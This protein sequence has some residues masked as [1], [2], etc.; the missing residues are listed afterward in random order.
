MFIV[1]KPWRLIAAG[2]VVCAFSALAAVFVCPQCGYENP[3]DAVTC[4]HC[5]ATL[6]PH[7]ATTETVKQTAPIPATGDNRWYMPADIVEKEIKLARDYVKTGDVAVARLF[8]KNAMALDLITDPSIE[9]KRAETIL[10]AIEDCNTRLCQ[11]TGKCPVCKGTGDRTVQSVD[12]QGNPILKNVIGKGCVMCNGRGYVNKFANQDELKPVLGTG[13][14]RYKMIQEGRKYVT[15]G[16]AWVPMALEEKL[17]VKQTAMLKVATATPCDN[18]LGF[19]TVACPTCNGVGK[20]KCPTCKGTG[21]APKDKKSDSN[22]DKKEKKEIGDSIQGSLAKCLVCN[23]TGVISCDK[24]QGGQTIMCPRCNGTGERPAC[25]ACDGK[26]W[27]PCKKCFGSGKLKDN[28]ICPICRG[29][30]VTLC[31]A[32]DGEGKKL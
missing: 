6:P 9:T 12:M 1:P 2:L 11:V 17:S 22:K 10:K 24:C 28:S 31:T 32:C 26:G 27:V 19:C 8:F 18:C 5:G 16:G 23:G 25:K 3:D 14:Q 30:G 20:V 15:V 29:E 7:A 4:L 21:L 13:A